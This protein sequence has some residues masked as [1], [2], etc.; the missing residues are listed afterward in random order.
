MTTSPKN[1]FYDEATYLLAGGLGGLGRSISRW[2]VRRGARHLLLLSRSGPSKPAAQRLVE[3]LRQQ[4]VEA[5]TLK[6][7]VSDLSAL[8]IVLGRAELGMPPIRGCI[9]YPASTSFHGPDGK[10]R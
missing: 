8:E 10:Q 5:E 7:D 6:C 3:E 4:D 9:Q 1:S 2:M